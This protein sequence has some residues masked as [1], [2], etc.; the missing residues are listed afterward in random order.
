M[1]GPERTSSLHWGK[2][3]LLQAGSHNVTYPALLLLLFGISILAAANA[4]MAGD[5]VE[6][7]DAI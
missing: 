7:G 2:R 6:T 4:G 1:V 5:A 3:K